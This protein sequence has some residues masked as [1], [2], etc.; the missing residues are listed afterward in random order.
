MLED[1]LEIIELALGFGAAAVAV[2]LAVDYFIDEQ[3]I[4]KEIKRQKK[5]KEAFRAEILEKKKHA[6]N[7]GIFDQEDDKLGELEITSEEGVDQSLYEHQII[8]L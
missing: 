5:F 6:V 2:S 8:Y 1:I 3:A 7:V 4:K